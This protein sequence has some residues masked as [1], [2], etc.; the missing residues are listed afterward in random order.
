V[1]GDAGDGGD[2]CEAGQFCSRSPSCMSNEGF[3]EDIGASGCENSGPEC[4]CDNVSYYNSCVRQQAQIGRASGQACGFPMFLSC[5]D[6]RCKPRHAGCAVVS[7]LSYDEFVALFPPFDPD[8]V[9][10]GLRMPIQDAI[11]AGLPPLSPPYA[12]GPY[13]VCWALPERCPSSGSQLV[14]A[15]EGKCVDECAAIEDGGGPYFPCPV[16]ASGQ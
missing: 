14:Q 11:E 13:G 9:C 16:D 15:C 6:P 7:P 10:R 4:G 5:S 1:I 8:K 12:G 3:C 2:H